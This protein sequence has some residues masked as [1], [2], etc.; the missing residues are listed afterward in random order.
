MS[1]MDTGEHK[2]FIA[3][4]KQMVKFGIVGFLAFCIDYGLFLVLTYALGIWYIA[5]STVSFVVST[6]FNYALSMRY[7]FQ[8]KETQTAMQQF[9]IFFVLSLVGLGLNQLILWACG[10]MLGIPAWIGKLIA[11]FLVMVYNF[12]TRKAFLEDHGR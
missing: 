12:V 1:P 8:G 7:V 3:L 9:A 4:I 6:V 2:G 11:T 5:A 10:D